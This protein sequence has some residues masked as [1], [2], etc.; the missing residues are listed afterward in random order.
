MFAV[1]E[2]ERQDAHA[3]QVAAMDPLDTATTAR[4]PW[5]SGPL[6]AQSRDDPEPYSRPAMTSSGTPS[7][8][9]CIDASKMVISAPSGRCAVH[10]PSLPPAS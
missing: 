4:T 10:P 6:A 5:R 8:W 2:L 7:P 9:Y 3:N 1:A